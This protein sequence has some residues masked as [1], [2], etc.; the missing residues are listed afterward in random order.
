M[1]L[2]SLALLPVLVL[3]ACTVDTTG[4]SSESNRG[5]HPQSSPNAAVVITEYSDL[6]CPACRTSHNL[7]TKP[8]L[9]QY[10]S[11]IRFEFHQFPLSSIHPMA[12]PAAEASECAA[13]QGKF[14]EFVDLAY[15]KQDQLS[16]AALDEWG[17]SLGLDVELYKRCRASHIKR[18]TIQAEYDEGRDAGIGGTPT[19]LVNGQMVPATIEDLGQAIE[20][21]T[22]GTMQRL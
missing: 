1:R 14:W 19:Y 8:L 20:E 3:V 2:Q 4:L 6:Q 22:A 21:A 18:E 12:M 16:D 10:G 13:D 11:R 7:V 5:P 9:E 17:Q 15:E